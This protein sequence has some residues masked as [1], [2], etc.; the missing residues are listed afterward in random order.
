[1]RLLFVSKKH[2]FL[3][4]QMETVQNIGIM[5]LIFLKNLYN[6]LVGL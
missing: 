1:M 5:L 3:K 4:K 2:V 6:T